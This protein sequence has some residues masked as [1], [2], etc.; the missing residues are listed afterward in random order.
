MTLVKLAPKI[1]MGHHENWD[2]TSYPAGLSGKEI[3]ESARITTIVDIYDALV[4]RRVY[5]KAN[6]EEAALKIMRQMIGKHFDPVL[7]DVLIDNLD[8]IRGIKEGFA[9]PKAA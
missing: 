2:G 1:T 6:S 5:K 3:P 9:K 7:F 8:I 4:H